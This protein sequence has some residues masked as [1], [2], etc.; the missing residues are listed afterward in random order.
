MA[1]AETVYVPLRGLPENPPG[2]TALKPD[3]DSTEVSLRMGWNPIMVPSMLV[4][5]FIGKS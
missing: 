5:F 3:V 1:P 4:N 2:T